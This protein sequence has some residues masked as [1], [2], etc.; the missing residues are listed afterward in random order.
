MSKQQKDAI[1]RTAKLCCF[2]NKIVRLRDHPLKECQKKESGL[3]NCDTKQHS[4]M[5]HNAHKSRML[6]VIV[7]KAGCYMKFVCGFK[8][9]LSYPAVFFKQIYAR[10]KCLIST[11]YK[12]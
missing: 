7:I 6:C 3:T 5:T 1:P 8:N 12:I 2:N 11:C 9:V 4:L 10:K